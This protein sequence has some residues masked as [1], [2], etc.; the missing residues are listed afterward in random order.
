MAAVCSDVERMW[1]ALETLRKI[2]GNVVAEPSE[3]KYRTLKAENKAVKDKV[4]ACRGGRQ[5]LEAAG[6]E[7]QNVGELARPELYVLPAEADLRHLQDT[8]TAIDALLANKPPPA[9]SAA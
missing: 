7:R 8:C 6:F 5:M 9:N 3:P 4:L 2:L 1:P